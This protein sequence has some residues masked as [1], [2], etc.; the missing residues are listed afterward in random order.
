MLAARVV[1]V[2]GVVAVLR[3]RL[4]A[5]VVV[6]LVVVVVV[7]L[8]RMLE[9]VVVAAAVV[10]EAP[11]HLPRLPATTQVR[12]SLSAQSRHAHAWQNP[13]WLALACVGDAQQSPPSQA[14][15]ALLFTSSQKPDSRDAHTICL[16]VR[17]FVHMD[18]AHCFVFKC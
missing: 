16:P 1:A 17:L 11:A 7:V 12:K 4:P 13:N 3:V 10:A 6:V 15:N 14:Q 18:F 8:A 9:R 5:A 2:A